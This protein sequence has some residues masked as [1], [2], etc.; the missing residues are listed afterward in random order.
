MG[1]QYI[2]V[3]TGLSSTQKELSPIKKLSQGQSHGHVS[4]AATGP[5]AQKGPGLGLMPCGCH[6]EIR[7]VCTKGPFSFCTG[8]HI[9]RPDLNII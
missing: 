9:T 4:C 1:K 6:L 7:H 3:T 8:P 2:P 5:H